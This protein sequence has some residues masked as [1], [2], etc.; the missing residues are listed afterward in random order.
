MWV[1][2]ER[3]AVE[4]HVAFDQAKEEAEWQRGEKGEM[5][6]IKSTATFNNMPKS[7]KV[8]LKER[9]S[10]IAKAKSSGVLMKQ[11]RKTTT[12]LKKKLVTWRRE[13]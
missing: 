7:L 3:S 9:S 2:C 13:L 8:Y 6:D 1:L 5:K 10:L 12:L 11:G 4:G